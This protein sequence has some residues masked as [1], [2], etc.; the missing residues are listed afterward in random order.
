VEQ[1]QLSNGIQVVTE[2]IGST[3]SV[4]LG[5]WVKTGSRN[6][7]IM[8]NGITH[9]IEHMLFKGTSRYSAREIAEFFDGLGGNINAFTSKENTCYYFIVLDEHFEKA[10]EVLADMFFHSIFDVEE[11]EKEKKVIYEEIA[12][13]ED[14]PDDQ[15]HDLI[16]EAAFSSHPLAYPILG[17]FER[18]QAFQATD[19]RAYMLKQYSNSNIVISVAGNFNNHLND[20]LERYFSLHQ[21]QQ[22]NDIVQPATFQSGLTTRTK[23]T[24]QNHLCLALPGL[25]LGD[26]QTYAMNALNNILGGGMSSRLFQEIREQRGLAYSVYTYH[27]A[28]SDS[29][30][31]VVYAGTAPEQTQEV[32]EVI[33]SVLQ[34]VLING[35]SELELKRTKEQLK[36]NFIL[37][38][39]SSHSKMMR[40]GRNQLMLGRHHSTDEVLK[41]ID[42]LDTD[43]LLQ[44]AERILNHHVSL[45][46][47][48][49]DDTALHN[50]RR[51]QLVISR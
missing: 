29:G 34:D 22:V 19:L 35:V 28:F 24:E 1:F 46:M 8:Q 48:G 44:V 25:P 37:S 21:N 43:Q 50:F 33:T 26:Q 17:N 6:E 39:E 15:V 4:A 11:L 10:L 30:L 27:T 40:L 47:V 5:I 32:L 38:T 9:F 13:Y 42:Q 49:V 14:T 23:Q 12:M 7:T 51:D 41:K 45:A 20:L 3:R 36:G 16:A 18:L 2:H 31:F